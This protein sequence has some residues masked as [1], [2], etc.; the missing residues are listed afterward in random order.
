MTL[1]GKIFSSLLMIAKNATVMTAFITSIMGMASE[2][3]LLRKVVSTKFLN[4][5]VTKKRKKQTAAIHTSLGYSFSNTLRYFSAKYR[6]LA[7]D[8]L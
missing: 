8:R 5:A 7:L 3:Y 6:I 1:S 4:R 2:P